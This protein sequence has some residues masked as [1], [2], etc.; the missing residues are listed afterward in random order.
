M[1]WPERR[2]DVTTTL[3][4]RPHPIGNRYP[5]PTHRTCPGDPPRG[6][7]GPD[8]GRTAPSPCCPPSPCSPQRWGKDA[9]EGAAVRGRNGGSGSRPPGAGGSTPSPTRHV[10]RRAQPPGHPCH[11]ERSWAQILHRRGTLQVPR[12]CWR[13]EE[14]PAPSRYRR[15]RS[16]A[17]GAGLH[18][19][20]ASGQPW[21]PRRALVCN[22]IVH[23]Q[24]K[25]IKAAE[26]LGRVMWL[27]WGTAPTCPW[28]EA[29]G[30]GRALGLSPL[31][32]Q[33]CTGGARAMPGRRLGEMGHSHGAEHPDKGAARMPRAL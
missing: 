15:G 31:G 2:A 28:G 9:S 24:A 30:A 4:A 21:C 7:L 8:R 6:T 12:R 25:T 17:L 27:Y 5:T 14:P 32:N 10:H 20:R 23:R 29:R 13:R 3:G 1:A 18:P 19:G 22:R 33:G 16:P 26:P 11:A